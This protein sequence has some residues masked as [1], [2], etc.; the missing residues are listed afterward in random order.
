[1]S[2][3]IYETLPKSPLTTDPMV[4]LDTTEGIVRNNELDLHA[5]LL[6]DIQSDDS[7]EVEKN[8]KR[9]VELKIPK[10]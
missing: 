3:G 8:R 6:L 4:T 10:S 7:K 1:M 2:D 9:A 5:S